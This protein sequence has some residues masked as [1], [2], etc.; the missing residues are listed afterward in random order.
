MSAVDGVYYATCCS[1][2]KY[3]NRDD[4]LLIV[5]DPGSYICG[6]FTLSTMPSSP[7]IWS[8]IN[9]KKDSNLKQKSIIFINARKL[10]IF[11]KAGRRS[12]DFGIL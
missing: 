6:C 4:L 5:L 12:A 9:N 10:K 2:T 7:V 8:K 11:Q 3:R 1:G